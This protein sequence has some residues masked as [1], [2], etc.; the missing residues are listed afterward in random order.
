MVITE[1]GCGFVCHAFVTFVS[2]FSHFELVGQAKFKVSWIYNTILEYVID[3]HVH[4]CIHIYIHIIIPHGLLNETPLACI[5]RRQAW[6][7]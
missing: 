1:C 3:R 4:A 6:L 5:H 2:H 7:S